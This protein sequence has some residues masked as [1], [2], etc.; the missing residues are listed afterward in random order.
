[1]RVDLLHGAGP[2]GERG[3]PRGEPD[4]RVVRDDDL[5]RDGATGRVERREPARVRDR[6]CVLRERRHEE[7][8]VVEHESLPHGLA[9]GQGEPRRRHPVASSTSAPKC[10]PL[11]AIDIAPAL[12]SP[13]PIPASV[14]PS[15]SGRASNPTRR[16]DQTALAG[17]S[18]YHATSAPQ[19]V[20]TTFAICKLP[21]G[22]G[23]P[24]TICG[25]PAT[26]DV[27]AAGGGAVAH[28]GPLADFFPR[29]VRAPQATSSAQPTARR[30]RRSRVPSSA[31]ARTYT[32]P[33]AQSAF[34]SAS[35]PGS[36]RGFDDRAER[37]D[38]D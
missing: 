21:S 18:A 33:S 13:A 7:R 28:A 19:S 23:G 25:A 30:V 32:S 15:V 22:G 16:V 14:T 17:P 24:P 1:M 10:E 27:H 26:Q 38:L 36:R 3:E 11:R 8:P 34:P 12:L 5:G 29:S 4:R 35:A 2:G 20:R 9:R 31:M 6:R 37:F